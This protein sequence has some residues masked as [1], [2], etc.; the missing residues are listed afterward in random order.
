MGLLRVVPFASGLMAK[1]TEKPVGNARDDAV[2][3][4]AGYSTSR[5]GRNGAAGGAAAHPLPD[6]HRKRNI[7]SSTSTTETNKW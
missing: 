1:L 5:S 2:P 3:G 7:S 4:N 6:D